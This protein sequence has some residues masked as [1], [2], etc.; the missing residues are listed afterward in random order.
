MPQRVLR[1]RSNHQIFPFFGCRA[2]V[3]CLS[4]LFTGTLLTNFKVLAQIAR[5]RSHGILC[6]LEQDHSVVC[7]RPN[8]S[9]S[10]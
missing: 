1:W 8:Q 4:I 6:D 5:I 10:R 7:R 3:N 2:N 9:A